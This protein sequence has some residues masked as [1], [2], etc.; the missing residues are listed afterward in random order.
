MDV[1]KFK[2]PEHWPLDAKAFARE[3]IS[4]IQDLKTSMKQAL[5]DIICLKATVER[6]QAEV[7]ELKAKL[8]TNSSNSSLPPSKD[9]P[10]APAREIKPTGKKQGAQA[11]HRGAGRD[12]FPQERVNH[13]MNIFPSFCPTSK[14]SFSPG[15]LTSIYFKPI[16][17]VDLPDEKILLKVTEARLHTCLCPCGCGKNLE[18]VMPPAMGNTVVGPQLKAMMALFA[19]RFRLS[20]RLIQELLVDIFG[21]DAKFSTGCISEAEAEITNSLNVPYEEAREEVKKAEAFNIDETSW[22]YKHDLQ[23][24]WVAVTNALAVFYI[25]PER[26]QAAFERFIGGFEGFIMSDRFS[27]YSKL[28]PEERQVCW[29]HLIRDFRKLVDR[30]CGAEGIGAWALQEIEVMFELWH[31]YLDKKIDQ[32]MLRQ[33]FIVIRARFARLLKLGQETTDPK[34]ARFCQNLIKVWPALWNFIQRP[35]ILQPTNNRAEQAVR[36]A[37]IMRIFSLGSQSVRGLRFVERMLTVVTTL[38]KQGRRV[39]EFLEQSL[40]SF[41]TGGI[42]PSLLPIPS[43]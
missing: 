4:E 37:V 41:R 16:Q 33:K 3:A 30:Q 19:G 8:G 24:L 28:S 17:Q 39:L 43:G 13:V 1:T 5:A 34:A 7:K 26:S 35:D 29:A 14:R 21:P 40:L 22:F 42:S 27:V 25:D 9:P 36:P 31:D 11:G 15:E 18:A 6:S 32:S 10:S 38:R 2:I 12:L 23:W 20:K